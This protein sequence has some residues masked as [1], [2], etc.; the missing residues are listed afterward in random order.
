MRK[1][2]CCLL[3]VATWAPAAIAGVVVDQE[4]VVPSSA[5]GLQYYLDYPGDHMAQTFTVAHSGELT[6]VGVQVS[7]TLSPLGSQPPIDDLHVKVVRTDAEGFAL[8]NDVLAEGTIS[9]TSLP[10][11]PMRPP[12]TVVDLTSWDAQVSA[13]EK[14]AIALT[15]AQTDHSGP[16]HGTDYLWWWSL[17]NPH[18][19]GEFSVYS[20][21]L[22]GPTPLRD[23]LR[24]SDNPTVDAGFRVYVNVVPEP[25]SIVV[26]LTLA[27]CAG[28]ARR[29]QNA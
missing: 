14:L 24:H 11:G 6:G 8:I 25:A 2:C 1:L 28:F 12:I 4:Y 9:P 18:P 3:V 5:G 13:G 16:S 26:A 7:L 29:R 20:P 10:F 15:S 21:Q 27:L 17:Y 23:W 19:G 22:Y